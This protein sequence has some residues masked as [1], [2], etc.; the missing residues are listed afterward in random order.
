VTTRK[1]KT[2]EVNNIKIDPRKIGGGRIDW[3]GL[4]QDRDRWRA[5]VNTVLKLRGLYE[6]ENCLS[7]AQQAAS[8][9]GLSIWELLRSIPNTR[10][11]KEGSFAGHDL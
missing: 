1:T 7:T 9:E 8:Q 10:G 6:F 4:A 11:S 5:L 3:I 2:K